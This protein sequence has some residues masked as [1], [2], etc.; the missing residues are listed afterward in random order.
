MQTK[1]IGRQPTDHGPYDPQ[2]AYGKK[3]IVTLFDCGWESKH[4][5]NTTAPATLNAQAGTI[6]PNIEHWIHRWG[7]YNQWLIDNGYKK[8]DASD[9]KDGNQSQHTINAAL[10]G[11]I[12]T[13]SAPRTVKGRIKNLENSVGS[14]GSVDQ[15]ITQAKNEVIGGASSSGNTLKK[16][17]DRVSPLEEAVGSGGSIDSRISSAVEAEKSRAQ[18]AEADR[19][20][21]SETYTKTEVNGLVDTPHQ[22]YVTVDAYSN[23]PATGSKDTIYRVSNYNGSTSQVDAS[24]YSEYAWNGTQYIFLCVKS[25]IG[26]VF[27]ISVYNN[28]AKYADL[29]A[30]LNGGANIPQSLQKGGMSVKFVQSSDN[31][32]VQY[33]LM[34][35]SFTTDTTKWQQID[36]LDLKLNTLLLYPKLITGSMLQNGQVNTEAAWGLATEE[37]IQVTSGDYLEI[38]SEPI[39]ID[40]TTFYPK[41]RVVGYTDKDASTCLANMILS[42]NPSGN[43]VVPNTCNYIKFSVMFWDSNNNQNRQSLNEYRNSRIFYIMGLSY[44]IKEMWNNIYNGIT[45][46]LVTSVSLQSLYIGSYN[47]S[48]KR[49]TGDTDRIRTEY[50][51]LNNA[52]VIHIENLND[53]F[54]YN[55]YLFDADL[56][57]VRRVSNTLITSSVADYNCSDAKYAIFIFAYTDDS[58]ISTHPTFRSDVPYNFNVYSY[59]TNK[60]VLGNSLGSLMQSPISFFE[61]F[62]TNTNYEG[63]EEIGLPAYINNRPHRAVQ[64]NMNLIPETPIQIKAKT[65]YKFI[66]EIF[67][68]NYNKITMMSDWTNTSPYSSIPNT[69]WGTLTTIFK[70]PTAKYYRLK[71][72]PYNTS[73]NFSDTNITLNSVIEAKYLN[74]ERER[75]L[76]S[77]FSSRLFELDTAGEEFTFVNDELWVFNS[78]SDDHTTNGTIRRYSMEE[79]HSLILLK[80]INH[81]LGHCNTVDYCQG[82]DCLILGNGSGS[83]DIGEKNAIYIISDVES[84]KQNDNI[85]LNGCLVIEF[86]DWSEEDKQYNVIWADDNNGRFDKCILFSNSGKELLIR[87]LQLGKGSNNL[88]SGILHEV[89]ENDFNGTYKVVQTNSYAYTDYVCLQGGCFYNGHPIMGISHDGSQ[90]AKYD[91][92]EGTTGLTRYKR[93]YYNE[94][95]ND[96]PTATEGC[97]IKDDVLYLGMVQSSINNYKIIGFK[98]P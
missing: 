4:D 61:G 44:S 66:V 54:K 94:N 18:A 38:K 65:G 3:F 97:A 85:L 72:A 32:Y 15:R 56:K 67:D 14:G 77:G 80:T 58:L 11:E 52:S 42:D 76:D 12:G 83:G 59:N 16:V 30:A 93:T 51:P 45:K 19:Y 33:M 63:K 8:I 6:T 26:E 74:I 88:G 49:K 36:V 28:N 73:E 87:T 62:V 75:V 89:E 68:A 40:N 2:L 95:G 20:T 91:L 78:S 31:K 57:F 47:I 92:L 79:D 23:L 96:I 22:E 43:F 10:I 90:V 48:T 13:D 27:D 81:N 35:Q 71:L 98:I 41:Y 17:E 64:M 5:N 24:V 37:F 55:I 21:K 39:I 53:V 29:A 84:K 50:L 34:A 69:E 70:S 86:S 7:S 46:G 25:Q 60:I 82:N 1:V 9:V